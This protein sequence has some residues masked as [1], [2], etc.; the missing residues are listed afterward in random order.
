MID[1]ILVGGGIFMARA[2]VS[3]MDWRLNPPT[4]YCHDCDNVCDVESGAK[5]IVC[6]QQAF[7]DAIA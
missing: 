1:V 4:T 3:T 2:K 6:E 5:R 7:F